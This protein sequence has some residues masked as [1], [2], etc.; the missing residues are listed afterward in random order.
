MTD[1]KSAKQATNR[2]ADQVL[3]EARA[4]YAP[5]EAGLFVPVTLGHGDRAPWSQITHVR[6]TG[7]DADT[8]EA[9]VNLELMRRHADGDCVAV[10]A[11]FQDEFKG[12]LLYTSPSP[13]DRQKSRMP[14]SA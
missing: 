11:D 7:C 10:I 9:I 2:P 5:S 6:L 13:R 14:S 3:N 4:S 8:T 1:Q 12:C